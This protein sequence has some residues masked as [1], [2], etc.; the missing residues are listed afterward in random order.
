MSRLEACRWL[1]KNRNE[2]AFAGNR[3]DNNEAALNFIQNL[4]QNGALEV[5]VDN[6][7]RE[8]WRIRECGGPYADSLIVLMPRIRY[9]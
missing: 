1:K 8:S 7:F 3:F 2:H 6:I 9:N 5:I 4:Y